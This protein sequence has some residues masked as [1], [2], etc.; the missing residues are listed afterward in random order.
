M[1]VIR[2][3]I[4]NLCPVR[5]K[6][7]FHR[8]S[9]GL[10]WRPRSQ[11]QLVPQDALEGRQ[12][13]GGVKRLILSALCQGKEPGPLPLLDLTVTPQEPLQLLVGPIHLPIGLRP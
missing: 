4:L 12:P 13:G 11:G 5:S 2:P 6:P 3:L 9:G 10:A 7:L 8:R 1:Q